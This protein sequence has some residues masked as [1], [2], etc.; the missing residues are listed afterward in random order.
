MANGKGE[1]PVRGTAIYFMLLLL[2]LFFACKEKHNAATDNALVTADESE[3]VTDTVLED[4]PPFYTDD[5]EL[6]SDILFDDDILSSDEDMPDEEILIDDEVTDTDDCLYCADADE[7]GIPDEVECPS[8]PCV[9]S[10]KDGTPDYLDTDSDGDGLSDAQE[11]TYG[12]DP[13]RV[14]TDEDG[15]DDKSEIVI[16]CDPLTPDACAEDV[17]YAVVIYEEAD[18]TK[19]FEIETPDPTAAGTEIWNEVTF[20]VTAEENE[21]GINA[22]EFIKSSV[23]SYALPAEGVQSMDGTSFYLVVP[24]TVLA[25]ELVFQNHIFEPTPCEPELFKLNINLFGDGVPIR[26]KVLLIIVQANCPG[27]Q[28]PTSLFAEQFDLKDR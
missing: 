20:E 19:T 17:V 28:E 8:Q 9:D 13:T 2:P 16:G 11:K 21:Y 6:L 15:I 7:D 18:R 12:T 3:P 25:Y 14:D 24:E 1:G 23:A 4:D 22:L 27:S 5:A 26:T 10:D